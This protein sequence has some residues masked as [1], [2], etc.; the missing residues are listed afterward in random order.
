MESFTDPR[1]IK[2]LAHPL[3]VKLLTSLGKQ[4]ASPSQLSKELGVALG[5]VS[6]HVRTLHDMGLLELMRE[7]RQRGAIEHYYTAVRWTI[8]QHTWETLPDT[9]KEAISSSVI[10]EIGDEVSSAAS[11]GA[12]DDPHSHLSRNTVALDEEGARQLSGEVYNLMNRAVEIEAEAKERLK[13]ANSKETERY[14]FVLMLF[15]ISGNS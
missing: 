1:I 8:P 14:N 15:G 13:Q 11:A 7:E 9:L 3:R 6:Y 2:A 4:E 5:T 12:F 10:A